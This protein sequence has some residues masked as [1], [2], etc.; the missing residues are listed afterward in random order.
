[1]SVRR[2]LCA[3]L[4]VAVALCP[5]LSACGSY[6]EVEDLAFID[7]LAVDR[8]PDGKYMVTAETT[9]SSGGGSDAKIEPR[10]LESTGDTIADAMENMQGFTVNE[11]YWSHT[12]LIIISQEIARNSMS[13][14]LDHMMRMPKIRLSMAIIVSKEATAREVLESENPTKMPNGPNIMNALRAQRQ[15]GKAPYTQL[16]ELV[17]S[18]KEEGGESVVALIGL[19]EVNGKKEIEISGA[20]VFHDQWL[21]GFIDANDSRIFLMAS[22]RVT[23][24]VIPLPADPNGEFTDATVEVNANRV[25]MRTGFDNGRPWCEIGIVAD[26]LLMGIDGTSADPDQFQAVTD[27]VMTDT[28]TAIQNS[29]RAMIQKTQGLNSSDILEVGAHLMDEHPE[30]W[31]QISGQWNDLYKQLDIHIWTNLHL[32]N[33]QQIAQ[34]VTGR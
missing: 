29:V 16:F 6:R 14:V 1:M 8:A 4:A 5:L 25:A 34:A 10:Y 9:T 23:R 20:A 3:A 15:L 22:G 21:Q 33:T 2:R 7:A 31:K 30:T 32:R 12:E 24:T 18:I 11:L 27:A 17:G 19:T 26:V 13:E 28:S